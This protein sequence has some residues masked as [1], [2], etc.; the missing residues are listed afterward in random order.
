LTQKDKYYYDSTNW[1]KYLESHDRPLKWFSFAKEQDNKN[2]YLE[3]TISITA[4]KWLIGEDEKIKKY[5]NSRKKL[6]FYP[7]EIFEFDSTFAKLPFHKKHW[8]AWSFKESAINANLPTLMVNESDENFSIR[9]R[10]YRSIG[11]NFHPASI[12]LLQEGTLDPSPFARSQA[13]RSLGWI[14]DP[15]FIDELIKIIRTDPVKEVRRVA[16]KAVQRIIGFWTFYGEWSSI[17]QNPEKHLETINKLLKMDLG[18]FAFEIT[19]AFRDP[20]SGYLIERKEVSRI[21]DSIKKYEL[22]S[23]WNSRNGKGSYPYYFSEAKKME[24]KLSKK[25][26]LKALDKLAQSNSEQENMMALN[27]ISYYSKKEY[28]EF[29]YKCLESNLGAISWNARRVLRKLGV[30]ELNQRRKYESVWK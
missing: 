6:H 14:K 12:Q 5:Q 3:S 19:N 25:I 22:K 20:D 28:I 21:A 26:S 18:A 27:Y 10:I 24:L 4:A 16:N 15:S 1:K 8:T 11:Q 29:V 9:A 2:E 13:I 17:A 7:S 30:G 23:D